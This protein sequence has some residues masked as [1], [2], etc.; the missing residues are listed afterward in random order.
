MSSLQYEIGVK[1]N[2]LAEGYLSEDVTLSLV[3]L[4]IINYTDSIVFSV[5]HT[6]T[7]EILAYAIYSNLHFDNDCKWE[8]LAFN[9][10]LYISMTSKY[11]VIPILFASEDSINSKV[12]NSMCKIEY[13]DGVNNSHFLDGVFEYHNQFMNDNC[14][15]IYKMDDKISISIFKGKNLLLSNAF[16]CMDESEIL[17]FIA[18]AIQV[19][20]I[21]KN[22]VKLFYDYS[23]MDKERMIYFLKPF[24]NEINS[25]KHP[26]I[27]DDRIPNL[28]EKLFAGYA[29]S[30]CV[31]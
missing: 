26:T 11:E 1:L 24:F 7:K 9:K 12:R 10:V 25:L 19:S 30:L 14:A 20:E 3:N 18:N 28:E 15:Y 21:E 6:K 2:L 16:D 29:I 31:L 27:K 13:N 5:Y 8:Q 23:I 22:S 4:F 17:Y